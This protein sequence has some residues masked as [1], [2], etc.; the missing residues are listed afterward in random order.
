MKRRAGL[1]DLV[2]NRLKQAPVLGAVLTPNLGPP[3]PA[4]LVSSTAP[5]GSSPG[6]KSPVRSLLRREILPAAGDSEASGVTGVSA[7]PEVKSRTKPPGKS[8]TARF[9][10]QARAAQ[11]AAD[12][13]ECSQQQAEAKAEKRATD[14]ADQ[15]SAELSARNMAVSSRVAVV[16]PY[17]VL[18][19]PKRAVGSKFAISAQKQATAAQRAAIRLTRNQR[20]LAEL[21]PNSMVASGPAPGGNIS[22]APGSLTAAGSSVDSSVAS[23]SS[24]VASSSVGFSFVSCLLTAAD[25][26]VGSSGVLGSSAAVGSSKDSTAVPGSLAGA[27]SGVEVGGLGQ[28]FLGTPLGSGDGPW[29]SLDLDIPHGTGAHVVEVPEAVSE[30]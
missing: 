21:K 30:A 12:V 14:A 7:A 6:S 23:G 18:S 8:K 13:A 4:A 20:K 10:A 16:A 25:S 9:A 27:I 22:V 17:K 11:L 15:E 24:A 1:P 29:N 19:C 26:S 28:T 2:L 5:P 3:N